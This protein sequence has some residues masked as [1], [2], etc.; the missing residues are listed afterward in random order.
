MSD[1]PH[2]TSLGYVTQ[3]RFL[4]T[5][6]AIPHLRHNGEPLD[7]MAKWVLTIL[8]QEA[9]WDSW[10]SLILNSQIAALGS[11][12]EPSVERAL[13][14]LV[15][16][17][18]IQRFQ[19]KDGGGWKTRIIV[20]RILADAKLFFG[21]SAK[22]REFAET[23][24]EP[25][26][27]GEGPQYEE[28]RVINM[29]TPPPQNDDGCP[30]DDDRGG[31]NLRTGG[32]QNGLLSIIPSRSVLSRLSPGA[33]GGEREEGQGLQ[34]GSRAPRPEPRPEPRQAPITAD[35]LVTYW[36]G[37]RS[38]GMGIA[39]ITARISMP[40][41]LLDV[42]AAL[43]QRAVDAYMD[44]ALRQTAEWRPMGA[45]WPK[46]LDWA[47]RIVQWLINPSLP[48]PGMGRWRLNDT[49]GGTHE[50]RGQATAASRATRHAFDGGEPE[51]A[52]GPDDLLRDL[53]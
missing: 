20:D 44:H 51:P 19:A 1:Q 36:N 43:A 7:R 16:A 33:P 21:T 40:P 46:F 22:K 3:P 29:M 53:F 5:I 13:A 9:D 42:P 2:Q 10:E 11:M 25:G 27:A 23:P 15:R 52:P 31:V 34:E 49:P 8:A 35:A 28:G 24:W 6:K 18:Y 50:R 45:G 41:I 48:E 38:R 26:P 30:Q 14:I 12:S 37:H 47:E 17:R 4:K 39:R 32:H